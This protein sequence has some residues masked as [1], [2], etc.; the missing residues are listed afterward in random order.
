MILKVKYARL[1]RVAGENFLLV[2]GAAVMVFGSLIQVRV[3]TGYL[4]P[5]Q[6]GQLALAQTMANLV[7]QVVMCGLISGIG[8]FYSIAAEKKMLPQ[9]LA[10]AFGLLN[11][12][13]VV[14]IGVGTVLVLGLVVFK[15]FHWAKLAVATLFFALIS[16]FNGSFGDIQNAAR[17]RGIVSFH[18]GLEVFLKIVLSVVMIIFFGVSS[19]TVMVGFCLA[20]LVVYGSHRYW[21]YKTIPIPRELVVQPSPEW[22][23]Q[24]WV[25]AWPFSAWGIFTWLQQASDRWS[26]ELFVTTDEVGLYTVLFQLGYAPIGMFSGLAVAFIIPILFQRAGDATNAARNASVHRVNWL[27]SWAGLI[28]TL[29]A[30]FATYILHGWI[31]RILVAEHYRN[32]SYL[33]PWF[34]LSGGFFATGQILA[35]KLLSEMRTRQLLPVKIIT[36]LVGTLLNVLGAWLAGLHGVV[37]AL[38]VFSFTYLIS[39][40]LLARHTEKHNLQL[41]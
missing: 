26:L 32:S 10:S 41:K 11:R 24:I 18:N 5:S 13:M 39:T 2:I 25:Y 6:Y 36:A 23:R 20:A 15:E 35:L 3:L 40:A 38:V 19:I 17:K 14:V 33:L 7:N 4:S 8:R 30:F 1:K 12:A 27:I 9:Y 22:M 37:A 16:N 29:I 31:F 34:I 28:I 21:L